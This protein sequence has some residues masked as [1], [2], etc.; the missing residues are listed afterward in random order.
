MKKKLFLTICLFFNIFLFSSEDIFT[1]T[2]EEVNYLKEN[3]VIKYTPDPNWLPYEALDKDGKHIGIFSDLLMLIEKKLNVKFEIVFNK[4]WKEALVFSN[5]NKIDMIAGSLANVVL[6]DKFKSIKSSLVN[7]IVIV[8]KKGH[9]YVSDLNHI[10]NKKIILI[11]EYGYTSKLIKAYPNIKFSYVNNLQDGL[12]SISEGENDIL[13]ASIAAATYNISYLGLN[14]LAIVGRTSV[15]MEIS[16]F[17]KKDKIILYNIINKLITQKVKY[18]NLVNEVMKK[19]TLQ[20]YAEKTNYILIFKIITVFII[21]TL[22]G[23]IWNSQLSKSKKKIEELNYKLKEKVDE[24]NKL[25]ITDSMTDLYNRR[26]FDKVF[27]QEIQRCNRSKRTLILLLLDAD[28]FKEYNDTYGH[29]KGDEVLISISSCMKK[30]SKRAND[31]AFRIGGE[32]FCIITSDVNENDAYSYSNKLRVSIENTLIEHK[33]NTASNYVTVS[34]G[35]VIV[36]FKENTLIKSSDIY[37]IA[38]KALYK[39]KEKGRNKIEKIIIE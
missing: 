9:K 2:K 28:K 5:E 37:I 11:K 38:D 16:F 21:I 13:L 34:I 36:K 27:E 1:L 15:D 32:E 3:P 12:I 25:S 31:F 4:S 24:L 17:I 10:P 35:L 6:N 39:A 33:K 18:S 26:Y 8:M 7:P 22:L 20:G 30:I 14:N 29:A 19:W 23:F